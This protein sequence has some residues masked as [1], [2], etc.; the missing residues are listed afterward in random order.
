MIILGIDPGLSGAV[1]YLGTSPHVVHVEDT[2]TLTV[3]GGSGNRREYNLAEM[4]ALLTRYQDI[5]MAYIEKV[6][7]MPGQG[8]R[9][10]F[11]MG[12]GYGA[13]LGMLAA[14][15]IP[16]TLVTPQRWKKAML[17]D[18]AGQDKDASRLRAIQLFPTEA[19]YFAR[20]KDDG[21]AEAVLIAE[22]GRRLG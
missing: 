7:S 4:R 22:Y 14:L 11:T 5:S 15:A 19:R 17:A 18:Q 6:H 10:M 2:P 21:R 16:Y 9:S 1:A 20:K 13:W 8:V 12:M 3:V